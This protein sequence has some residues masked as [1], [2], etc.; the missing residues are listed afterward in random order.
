MRIDLHTHS[1]ASDG[2]LSPADVVRAAAAAGVDVLAL[3]D[4]DTLAGLSAAQDA[5]H[6]AGV[7]LVRGVEISCTAQGMSV[8]LLGYGG[9]ESDG[10]LRAELD[11]CRNDR[12]PRARAMVDRLAAA[13]LPITWEQVQAL[14]D[15]RTVGRP[16]LADA[17]V[18][19]GAAADREDAF[20]R[21]L[22]PDGPFYVRHYAAPAVAA[23]RLVRAVGGVPV[24]AHPGAHT[25][26]PTV[27]D[28]TVAEIAAAGLFAL[29]VDHPD[30]DAATRAHLR[31]LA[32]D[33][34]LLVTGASDFHGAGRPQ[35]IGCETTDP[36]V[37]EALRAE[38][39]GRP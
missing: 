35:G 15:D 31:G 25:R 24:F 27:D 1:T 26:G 34:G 22:R 7:Q 14:A 19:G 23:V 6:T 13:G 12:V 38:L 5:A 11:R 21:Y 9:D 33:L 3:T 8:H 30:H 2:T 18:A 29:E 4:H 20:V 36:E 10:R 37:Y 32:R 28:D 17:L 16:H 39:A